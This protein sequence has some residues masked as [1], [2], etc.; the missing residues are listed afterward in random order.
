MPYP[1]PPPENSLEDYLTQFQRLLPRGR[2]W[3]R[4]WG[5]VQNA[6]LLTLMPAWSR[7]QTR[8]NALIGE[9]FPCTTNE[10]LPEWEATLGLP[11]CG[12]PLGTQQE[13]TAAVCAKF[14]A[15]GGQTPAYFIRLA[16]S[17][18]FDITITQFLPFYAGIGHAGDPVYGA[19]WAFAWQITV[20]DTQITWF[21]A[22]NSR[23]GDPLALWGNALLECLIDNAAP[24][25]TV[26]IWDYQI[27][28]VEV[29]DGVVVIAPGSG[30]TVVLPD[31][32]PRYIDTGPLAALTIQLPPSPTESNSIDISFL[33]PVAALTILDSAG[34]PIATATPATAYGPGAGIEFRYCN[35]GWVYW[36]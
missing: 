7:L 22:S 27:P 3:H 33:S 2:V 35:L 16:A 26:I 21:R 28:I 4:G 8:L 15:R 18:G 17:V 1:Y 13:R 24:A 6:D 5:W 30:D 36:A 14:V 25:H 31:F 23:A 12:M 11:D 34:D 20:V 10:L 29:D 32:R 19:E 9:I